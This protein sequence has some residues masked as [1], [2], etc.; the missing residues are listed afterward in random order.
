[1][2]I[3]RMR[4]LEL[5]RPLLR[6]TNNGITATFDPIS[7]EQQRL[8]QFEAAVLNTTIHK[9]KGETF[10]AEH[11]KTPWWSLALLILLISVWLNF[12]LKGQ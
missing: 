7:G 6:V 12:R 4:A 9:I 10:Y 3:A 1:M 8:A 11:G 5:G 2:Q